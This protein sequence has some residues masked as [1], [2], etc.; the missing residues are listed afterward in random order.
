MQLQTYQKEFRKVEKK[1]HNVVYKL[2]VKE[3]CFFILVF[4]LILVFFL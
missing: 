1:I 4:I 3:A 2:G